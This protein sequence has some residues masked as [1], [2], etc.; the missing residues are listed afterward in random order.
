MT[1]LRSY[2]LINFQRYFHL[3]NTLVFT[4]FFYFLTN[5]YILSVDIMFISKK[6][7][8]NKIITDCKS[9][10]TDYHKIITDHRNKNITD[11]LLLKTRS[12]QQKQKFFFSVGTHLRSTKICQ[13]DPLI[14]YHAKLQQN[15]CKRVSQI[16]SWVLFSLEKLENKGQNWHH[17]GQKY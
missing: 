7:K 16:P 2:V 12:Y 1:P 13:E 10:V 14:F 11:L 8:V 5:S 17:E 6:K 15:L 4:L 9:H 3:M